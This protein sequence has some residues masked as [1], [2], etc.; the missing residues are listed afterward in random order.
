MDFNKNILALAI[1]LAMFSPIQSSDSDNTETTVTTTPV[2]VTTSTDDTTDTTPATP[3]EQPLTVAQP[4]ALEVP[5]IIPNSV[6]EDLQIEAEIDAEIIAEAQDFQNEEDNIVEDPTLPPTDNSNTT[7]PS[8]NTAETITIQVINNIY[9]TI[10]S[11]I[12]NNDAAALIQAFISDLSNGKYFEIKGIKFVVDEIRVITPGEI[13][14]IEAIGSDLVDSAISQFEKPVSTTPATPV[15]TS[16][17]LSQ[18]AA[19]ILLENFANTLTDGAQF[20]LNGIAYVVED[21][22]TSVATIP[23]LPTNN[24]ATTAPV[25]TTTT[26]NN[27]TTTNS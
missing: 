13:S 19:V 6:P 10:Y 24:P 5:Y 8:L 11:Q 2:V 1:C 17:I 20:T 27:P 26:N 4:V 21:S 23:T 22:T 14:I 7:Q 12:S 16:Q 18:E 3:V 15:T 9:A 25:T